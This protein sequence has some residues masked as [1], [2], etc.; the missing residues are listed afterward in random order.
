VQPLGI[1]IPAPELFA[2]IRLVDACAG[3]QLAP[4]TGDSHTLPL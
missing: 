1:R 2:S 4:I 3:L